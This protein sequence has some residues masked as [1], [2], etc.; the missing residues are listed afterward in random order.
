MRYTA[1]MPTSAFAFQLRPVQCDCCHA[2]WRYRRTHRCR[3][4]VR[5]GVSAAPFWGEGG[6]RCHGR[7]CRGAGRAL[8]AGCRFCLRF[9]A[10]AGRQR[11]STA[12]CGGRFPPFRAAACA[13]TARSPRP[14]ARRR[15]P[16][17]RLAAP[18]GFRW[19]FR[20]TASPRLPAWAGL[21]HH[22]DENGF[23]LSVKR[24]LLTHEGAALAGTPWRQQVMWA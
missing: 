23:H 9:A 16:S 13:P 18:T 3:A 17:A 11:V 14:S 20:V 24:W 5:I 2:F 22:D 7:A 10:G 21:A 19:S 1:V 6:D 12:G 8:C 4:G 15:A